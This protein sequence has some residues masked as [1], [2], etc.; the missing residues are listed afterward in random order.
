MKFK[1]ACA[2]FTFPLLPHDKVLDLIQML[3]F[4]GVDIGIF[5]DRSHLRPPEILE[6]PQ[7]SGAELG[8]K[9]DDRNLGC[10]D[11]FLI[12]GT[13]F[14]TYA[15]NHPDP[16]PRERA[17]DWFL[18]TL[19]FAAAANSSHVSM[20]PGVYFE[21]R[22]SAEK[23]W[24]RC[25]EELNWR[26]DKAREYNQTL[27][28]EAHLGSIV[29]EPKAALRLLKELPELSLTLDYTHFTRVGVPDEEI[30]PLVAHATHFHARGACEGR[31]QTTFPRN[32]IDYPR[33]VQV[34]DETNYPGY[35]GVE[36]VWIEWERLNEVDNLS[37]TIQMRDLLRKHMTA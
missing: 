28:V 27:G 10:A 13:E 34:M 33:I 18:R 23:S 37:E 36:Y 25:L 6:N 1:L 35:I 12:M 11:A 4:E 15:I 17:R 21:S 26:L 14:D 30:E 7:Q 31:L 29:P 19:D 22:E 32:S 8:K 3:E 24:E 9:L 5:E 20:L 16:Q 2:D